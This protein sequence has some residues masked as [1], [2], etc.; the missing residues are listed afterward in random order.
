MIHLAILAMLSLVPPADAET[1]TASWYST[2]KGGMTAAHKTLPMG[3]HVRVHNRHNGRS[4]TVT[5]NDRGPFI[6]GR[7]IDLSPAAR[8]ALG[9]DGLA[10]VDVE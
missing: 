3:S 6:K 2:G 1:C 4:V 7:C 5:I 10:P 9:I 8:D